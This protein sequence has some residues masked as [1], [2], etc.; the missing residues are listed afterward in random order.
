VSGEPERISRAIS[1][2]IGNAHK[3]SPPG[4]FIEIDLKDGA[5]A[6]RDH[7]AGFDEDDLPHVFD[8]FYRA[9]SARGMPGSGLGL[10]IVR[11]AAEAHGGRATAANAPGGGALV[12]ISFGPALVV[13]H[14]ETRAS[15]ALGEPLN[16]ALLEQEREP[17]A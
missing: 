1:N 9:D 11:Q 6:V 15:G 12:T 7:G 2:V 5:L 3:W 17:R 14:D 13:G 8:R 4:G 10:A 16:G